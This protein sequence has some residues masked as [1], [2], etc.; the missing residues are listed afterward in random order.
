LKVI[1]LKAGHLI[2]RCLIINR[3][4][5]ETEFA[6]AKASNLDSPANQN[7]CVGGEPI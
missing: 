6:Q 1:S 7:I 4:N 5:V 3:L 2:K